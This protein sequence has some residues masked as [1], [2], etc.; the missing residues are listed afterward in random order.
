MEFIHIIVG[1]LL[2]LLARKKPKFDLSKVNWGREM[3]WAY[4]ILSIIAG[5]ESESQSLGFGQGPIRYY[6]WEESVIYGNAP[7]DGKKKR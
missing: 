4:S 6:H 3:S 2:D 5:E 1:I 7:S